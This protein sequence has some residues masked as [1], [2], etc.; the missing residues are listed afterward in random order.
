MIK[1]QFFHTD[2]QI[3]GFLMRGHADSGDYG[4]DIVCAAVSVLAINT[5]NSLEQLA[6]AHPEV[7]SDDENGG[8]LKVTL[9]AEEVSEQAIQLFLN[10]LKL[11]LHDITDNYQKYLTIEND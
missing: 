2:Q 5:V 1:V 11:G 6:L 8:Y 7:V 10:S 9:P 4:H 3:S